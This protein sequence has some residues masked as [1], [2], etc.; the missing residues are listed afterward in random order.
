M[1]AGKINN[2]KVDAAL[3]NLAKASAAAHDASADAFNQLHSVLTPVERE[4]LVDKIQA[5]WAIWRSVNVEEQ[6]GSHEK[7]SHLEHFAAEEMKPRLG[8]M[9][10]ARAAAEYTISRAASICIAMSASIHWMP[11]LADTGRP[12]AWRSLV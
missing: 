1:A 4:V 10:S 7:G 6:V 3:K 2:G 8:S 11:W 9:R 5:H 12:N